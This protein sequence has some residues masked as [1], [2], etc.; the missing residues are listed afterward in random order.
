MGQARKRGTFEDR[1][2]QALA[3]NDSLQREVEQVAHDSLRKRL[4]TLMQKHGV[5]QFRTSIGRHYY[6]TGFGDVQE[7]SKA[8]KATHG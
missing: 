6:D 2:R 1:L 8:G 5:Q 4:T 3:A 7:S